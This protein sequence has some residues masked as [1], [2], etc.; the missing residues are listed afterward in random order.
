MPYLRFKQEEI[1]EKG[2]LNTALEIEGQPGLWQEVYDLVLSQ[3]KCIQKFLLPLLENPDLRIILTGAG[4]SAFIGEAAQGL[5][6]AYT[7]KIT[8]AIATTNLITHP[9]LYFIKEMPTLLVSFAR[10]GNSPESLAAV[11]LANEY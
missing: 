7:R 11:K 3:K 9:Q 6:Q 8:N 10:S 1:E 5:V 4:S 2:G